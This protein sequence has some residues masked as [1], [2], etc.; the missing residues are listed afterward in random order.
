MKS[1]LWMPLLPPDLR[2]RRTL[3]IIPQTS[4]V[5]VARRRSSE[6]SVG[7]GP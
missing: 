7:H 3:H 6:M 5:R 2:S 1:R 4:S